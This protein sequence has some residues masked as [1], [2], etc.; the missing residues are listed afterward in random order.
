MIYL[1]GNLLHLLNFIYGNKILTESYH[2]TKMKIKK[3]TYQ[4]NYCKYRLY[5]KCCTIFNSKFFFVVYDTTNDEILQRI[6]G[7]EQDCNTRWSVSFIKGDFYYVTS[8][9]RFYYIINNI[10]ISSNTICI[11]H[12]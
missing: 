9:N 6:V 4:K 11:K 2:Q 3:P 1:K 12:K 5:R 8:G 7:K 10:C